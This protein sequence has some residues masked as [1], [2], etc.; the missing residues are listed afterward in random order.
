MPI[1]VIPV[2][3]SLAVGLLMFRVLGGP[4]RETMVLLSA[5]L[6]V[7]STGSSVVLASSSGR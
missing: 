3:S 1:L 7:M 6:R 5:W 2:V 4:I